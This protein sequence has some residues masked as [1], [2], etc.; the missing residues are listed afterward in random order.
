MRVSCYES[1][2]VRMQCLNGVL[3]PPAWRTG[4]NVVLSETHILGLGLGLGLYD[5]VPRWG[6]VGACMA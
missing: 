5:A 6:V 4:G 2:S 1:A 3:L